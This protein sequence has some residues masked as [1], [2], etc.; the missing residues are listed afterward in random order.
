M[1]DCLLEVKNLQMAFENKKSSFTAVDDLS[2]ELQKGKTLGIVGESGSGKTMT[3]L[4][5]MRLLPE[6]GHVKRGEILFE[7]RD[8]LKLPAHEMEKI[9]GNEISMIFQDP[10]MSLDQVYTAGY[11]IMEAILT[12]RSC[13]RE[14]AK[15]KALQLISA[16]G[17]PHPERVFSSYPFEL[18]GGMCQRVMIAIALSCNPKLLFADEPTTALDVT[19][20]AQILDLLRDMQKQYQMGIVLITHDL[21]VVAEIADDI[22]V[23]Y[24]GQAM[25]TAPADVILNRPVHPYTKGLIRSMP[26]VGDRQDR[27]YNI[28]GMVPDIRHMPQGCRFCTRCALADD[29]CRRERPE[30]RMMEPKHFVRCHKA[31]LPPEGGPAVE[32]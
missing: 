15:R 14:E 20:Q 31:A 5:V 26:K 2:F 9:R 11:Q 16:V 25:E 23:M 19:V 7:G 32:S 17:I 1:A 21:G 4:S 10:M 22:I 13:G 3:S 27:L 24:A 12:H 30:V 6:H 18:S 8:L 28:E 29:R